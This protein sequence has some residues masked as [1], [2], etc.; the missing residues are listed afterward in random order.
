MAGRSS[1]A[2]YRL[3]L[4]CRNFA[5]FLLLAALTVCISGCKHLTPADTT[6]LDGVGI[7][8]DS[9]QQL[10]ALQ[11]TA[12]EVAQVVKARQAGFYDANCV[13]A[14]R[15]FHTRGQPFDA[16]DAIAGL[17]QAGVAQDTILELARMNQLGLGAGELQA[18][19]LA[20]LSDSILLE[21]AQHRAETRPV[22]AGASLAALKNTGLR[23]S[24]LLELARHGV[25]DSEAG[26]ILAFRRQGADDEQILRRFAG[27]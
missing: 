22:L 13:E 24:T 18:M 10:K 17:V 14:V 15:A 21:V 3:S 2:G 6:P 23:E 12:P 5:L 11:I 19:K 9:I 4:L 7:S 25:P 26:A 20:G 16:G 27:S 8:Y 1:R